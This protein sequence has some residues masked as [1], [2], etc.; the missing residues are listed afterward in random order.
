MFE[1]TDRSKEYLERVQA[2][3]DRHIY[4][5]EETYEEQ[6]ANM[7]TRWNGFPPALQGLKAKAKAEAEVEAEVE[8]EAEERY[9]S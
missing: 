8:A 4:P 9:L 6:A 1:F 5:A 2:F 3:L 7:E